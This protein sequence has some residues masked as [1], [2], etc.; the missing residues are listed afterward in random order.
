MTELID[1]PHVWTEQARGRDSVTWL[2]TRLTVSVKCFKWFQ[3]D[4]FPPPL[5]NR[6]FWFDSAL[7]KCFNFCCEK[8]TFVIL[9]LQIYQL[10]HLHRKED[11]FV[12]IPYSHLNLQFRRTMP[13]LSQV[14]TKYY[15]FNK[16]LVYGIIKIHQ[17]N[18]SLCIWS[19]AVE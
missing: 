19:S 14:L 9:F 17:N 5:K 11:G 12:F 16:S 6:M 15:S 3:G 7:F 8:D 13:P 2:F 10:E 4:Q 1:Q 18:F